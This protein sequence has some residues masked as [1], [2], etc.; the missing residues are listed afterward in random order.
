[1]PASDKLCFWLFQSQPERILRL[2][3]N[4]PPPS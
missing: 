1:M 4:L 3:N 2:L